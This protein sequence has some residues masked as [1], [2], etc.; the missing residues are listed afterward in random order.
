MKTIHLI[1]LPVGIG[2]AIIVIS[3]WVA[4]IGPIGKQVGL[5]LLTLGLFVLGFMGLPMI[6]RKELP[7]L[8]TTIR[9]KFAI[10]EG[11]V[12]MLIWW[13]LAIALLKDIL[14][15]K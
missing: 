13:G 7:W 15:G 1:M 10:F 11:V 9:G 12:L 14:G 6:I 4:G 5:G 8:T 3:I 2:L